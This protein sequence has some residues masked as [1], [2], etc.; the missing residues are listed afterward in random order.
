MTKARGRVSEHGVPSTILRVPG[1]RYRGGQAKAPR[2]LEHSEPGRERSLP[3]RCRDTPPV[4]QQL[5]LPRA[6][7]ACSLGISDPPKKTTLRLSRVLTAHPTCIRNQR[8]FNR[9][10]SSRY[11][12]GVAVKLPRRPIDSKT[13]LGVQHVYR[14]RC[15]SLSTRTSTSD[16][17]V[18]WSNDRLRKS[19]GGRR[20][21]REYCGRDETYI[22]PYL[23]TLPRL[24][25]SSGDPRRQCVIR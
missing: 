9:T 1:G 6:C 24:T 3:P 16:E 7:P 2:R 14:Y 17:D 10:E 5:G 11:N 25:L 12:V 20:H 21:P 18:L 13:S 4:R 15:H 8:T 23:G 19:M 22:G